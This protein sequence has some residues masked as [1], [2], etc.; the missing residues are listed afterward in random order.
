LVAPDT[1]KGTQTQ[2]MD[3]PQFDYKLALKIAK[4][5]LLTHPFYRAWA[6]GE[7]TREDLCRYAMQYFHHVAAFPDYLEMFESRPELDCELAQAVA[8]NRAGE[9]GHADLWLDFAEGMRAERTRVAEGE[10]LQEIQELIATFQSIA[11]E[12]S[13]AESLAAFY[14]YESQVPRIAT[15]KAR[16]LKEHYAANE[17]TCAYFTV[18]Q[19]ADVHHARVW[20]E[21]L[22]KQARDDESQARALEAAERT[23]QALW[24]ALDGIERERLARRN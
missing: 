11:R 16:G 8:E 21:Q 7:L 10:P 18:H 13:P 24:R 19:T 5:D 23:A 14:A 4:Y 2:M 12:G 3:T 22:E 15:E 1:L 9:A 17:E 6:C 20:N